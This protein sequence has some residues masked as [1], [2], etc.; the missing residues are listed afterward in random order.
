MG[1]QTDSRGA[2]LQ[3]LSKAKVLGF[4]KHTQDIFDVTSMFIL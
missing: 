3:A 1:Q 2:T 4:V